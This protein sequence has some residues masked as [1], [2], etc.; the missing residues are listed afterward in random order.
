MTGSTI[1]TGVAAN[2]LQKAKY[3]GTASAKTKGCRVK[4][5]TL[6]MFGLSVHILSNPAI[7]SD[8]ICGALP[9]LESEIAATVASGNE[10]LIDAGNYALTKI[11]ENFKARLALDPTFLKLSMQSPLKEYF[12]SGELEQREFRL[13]DAIMNHCRSSSGIDFSA[14]V[15]WALDRLTQQNYMLCP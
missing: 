9:A 15:R 8:D 1:L 11:R 12:E 7:A 4:K 5:L 14:S 13:V 2:R 6:F 3:R 10:M